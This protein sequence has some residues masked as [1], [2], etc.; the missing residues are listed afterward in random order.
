M[1]MFPSPDTVEPIWIDSFESLHRRCSSWS[2]AEALAID[3]EFV[4][5]RTFFPR[6]GLI[7]VSD[8]EEHA[9]ID[10]LAIPDLGPLEEILQNSKVTKVLHSC[11]EDLEVF[12][13][14]FGKVPK[15]VFDTQIGAAFAKVGNSLGYSRLVQEF[16]AVEL[17]KEETRSNWLKRPLTEG[18]M[19]YA[20]LDVTYLLPLFQRLGKRLEELGRSDWMAQ[21]I[22]QLS[23]PGRFLP[24]PS[25]AFL[26]LAHPA[27]SQLE[28]A[29][30]QALASWRETEAR[31][32]DLPR[33][34]VLPKNALTEIARK[35]PK[36]SAQLERLGIL[37]H[38]ELR[39]FGESLL[40][41]LQ[42][43]ADLSPEEMPPMLKRPRDLSPH[44]SQ[45][46]RFRKTVAKRAEQLGLAP[47]LL[48][49][50]KTVEAIWRRRLDGK[51][52]TIPE[53][54]TPWRQEI[55]REVIAKLE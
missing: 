9:L 19:L 53:A 51:I 41:I 10:P 14:R 29:T 24:D 46:D 20:A 55:L 3:T 18:Q 2:R 33:N 22:E 13:H 34:F 47:E 26:K 6:L 45:V 32:R 49:N 4:R 5:T 1:S 36:T 23:A 52:P 39:R 16:S 43:T 27:M 12:Y 28:L 17:P 31:K 21:E 50:R 7:Q 44:K 42:R 11:G 48:A 40:R 15:P 30:L 25:S 54:M 38:H 35:R 37:K 8:G